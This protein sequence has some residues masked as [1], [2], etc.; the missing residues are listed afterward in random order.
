MATL[1]RTYLGLLDKLVR[2]QASKTDWLLVDRPV[3]VS[4]FCLFFYVCT[5]T[6]IIVCTIIYR[7]HFDRL[8]Y[9][10]ENWNTR[11]CT[12]DQEL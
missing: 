3:D 2:A 1:V 10:I 11:E 5:R 12:I 4:Y 7:Y 8:R 6:Y 9:A